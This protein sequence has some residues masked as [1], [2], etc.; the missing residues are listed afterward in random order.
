MRS[1]GQRVQVSS[2]FVR[3]GLGD[4]DKS[5][6]ESTTSINRQRLIRAIAVKVSKDLG[7]PVVALVGVG[8]MPTEGKDEKDEARL[9]YVAASRATH[10]LV[11]TASGDGAFGRRLELTVTPRMPE[12]EI[13]QT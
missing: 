8:H 13:S 12:R 6:Y 7:L 9:F 3:Y 1:I 5:L 2:H 10:R 11:I 4:R